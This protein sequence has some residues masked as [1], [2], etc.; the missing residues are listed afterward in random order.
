MAQRVH[1]SAQIRR[2]F[3]GRRDPASPVPPLAVILRSGRGSDV[4]LKLYLSML[5]IAAQPPHRVSGTASAWATL[6]DLDEPAAKGARQIRSAIKWLGKHRLLVDES[7]PGV[8]VS[9][10]LLSDRGTGDDYSVPGAAITRAKDAG[11][12]PNQSDHYDSLPQTF[13][14]R[15]WIHV[16]SGPA[17]AMLLVLLDLRRGREDRDLWMSESV[18][19]DRYTLSEETRAKGLAELEAFEVVTSSTRRFRSNT[20]DAMRSRRVYR[21]DLEALGKAVPLPDQRAGLDE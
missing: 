20:L 11:E 14:T 4:R 12:E 5:W 21:L 17:I 13:W 2:D 9:I 1:R 10:T 19:S 18:A 3:V 8:G 15:G 16:L 7:T 6:L